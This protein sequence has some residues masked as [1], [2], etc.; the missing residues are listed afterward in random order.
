MVQQ[1]KKITIP[2]LECELKK[3][4]RLFKAGAVLKA[5]ADFIAA[6]CYWE[7]VATREPLNQKPE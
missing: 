1:I 5:A 2:A 7:E 4:H 6:L 3:C